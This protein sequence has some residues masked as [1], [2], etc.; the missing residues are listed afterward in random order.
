M[1]HTPLSPSRTARWLACPG[2]AAVEERLPDS[3][4]HDV[5][6]VYSAEGTAA[7]AVLEYWLSTGQKP[8]NWHVCVTPSGETELKP[9][10]HKESEKPEGSWFFEVNDDMLR[11]VKVCVDYV[12]HRLTELAPDAKREDAL[13]LEQFS[14]PVPERSDTGGRA[15]IVLAAGDVVEAVDYKHGA[16]VFVPVRD[17]AQTRSYLL[18]VAVNALGEI[19]S[20]KRYFHTIVQPRHRDSPGVMREE[21]DA[22]ALTRFLGELRA[23]A[24]L[25]DDARAFLDLTD[26]RIIPDLLEDL[27]ASGYVSPGSHCRW[28]PFHGACPAEY[29]QVTAAVAAEEF[30]EADRELIDGDP[31]FEKWLAMVPMVRAW[32][33]AVEQAALR[34]MEN[35][36]AIEGWEL[37]ESRAG[38]K[39]RADLTRDQ[40][41][42]IAKSYG[43]SENEAEPRKLLT[44]PQVEK[45]IPAGEREA[46]S[47]A[48]MEKPKGVPALRRVE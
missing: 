30:E 36:G 12:E 22:S 46:F 15:D 19:P 27:A 34:Y 35:G 10:P 44:G 25:V 1:K 4:E 29:D 42:A 2:S 13:R 33:T 41:L 21:L 5:A 31:G 7:H 11:A 32:T 47:A 40:I 16:G 9:S 18:G 26:D 17:N 3:G 48:A 6:T 20:G 37:G 14:N 28:C 43:I 23:G 45:L 24:S 38:R 8:E 39:W